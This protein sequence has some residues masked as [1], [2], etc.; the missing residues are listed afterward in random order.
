MTQAE[1]SLAGVLNHV[2]LEAGTVPGTAITATIEQFGA[3]RPP[4]GSALAS[5][6]LPS[7]LVSE[8]ITPGLNRLRAVATASWEHAAGGIA[9]FGL[10]T[11]QRL[12]G[13]RAASISEAAV[14]LDEATK[15]VAYS[16][17]P[18]SRPRWLGGARFAPGGSAWD[19]DWDAFGGWQFVLPR[20]LIATRKR[21]ASGNLT[22]E[23]G[24]SD[25][26]LEI[27]AKVRDALAAPFA[28]PPLHEGPEV[29]SR[30]AVSSEAWQIA[31]ESAL[32][33]IQGGRYRKVVLARKVVAQHCG[34]VTPG[35]I[36]A[37]L[38]HRYPAC[39]VFK[40]S[41]GGCDWL[42]ASPELLG[43]V[44]GTVVQAASLAGTRRRSD[45]PRIDERLAFELRTNPKERSE[46]DFVATAMREALAPLCSELTAPAEPQVMSIPG[47]HHLHTPFQG[48]L[49]NGLGILDVVAALHP[50]PAVGG[51]PR[52]AAL[53]AI[54]RLEQLD[55]GWYAGPVGWTDAEGNGQFAVA[56]RSGLID[57]G[58]AV[59]F[60]GAGI[61][62][63]SDP[64]RELAETELKLRPLREALVGNQ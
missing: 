57:G 41:A 42:G 14:V 46:H 17:S 61:V 9:L 59:L 56:L 51:W 21:Q 33:E 1:S 63:G 47:I 64:K 12:I 62:A 13:N 36:L 27:E 20:L 5:V 18:E 49:H 3:M 53:D 28:T 54:E 35:E 44:E 11:A 60:A 16:G 8:L 45:D 15:Q 2:R 24:A 43:A 7:S 38:A 58:H 52:T 40:F 23:L 34:S 31:V 30:E 39:F 19:A 4:R 25:S 29:R 26:L 50:T 6:E 55:R 48:E 32:G 37:R 10:G 22:L